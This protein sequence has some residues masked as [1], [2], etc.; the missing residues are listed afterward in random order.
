MAAKGS[1]SL[2]SLWHWWGWDRD[3]LSPSLW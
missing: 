3:M 1:I 2:R